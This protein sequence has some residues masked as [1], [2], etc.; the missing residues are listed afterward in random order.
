MTLALLFS[1]F[2]GAYLCAPHLAKAWARAVPKRALRCGLGFATVHSLVIL[3]L[4][5]DGE[6]LSKDSI[7]WQDHILGVDLA[8]ALTIGHLI[9]AF[10]YIGNSSV[11][12]QIGGILAFGGLQWFAVGYL[13][14][15]T[16]QRRYRVSNYDWN[17]PDGVTH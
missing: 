3:V 9:D 2:A 17:Q 16:T 1:L 10:T 6:I 7:S 12:A 4:L 13:Y 5:F 11:V 14:A 15:V 8:V